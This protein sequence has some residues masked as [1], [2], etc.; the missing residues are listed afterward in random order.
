MLAL[1]ADLNCFYVSKFFSWQTFNSNVSIRIELI[2]A[3]SGHKYLINV[4]IRVEL[5]IAKSGRKNL[6][7]VSIQVELIT[8][9]HR[10]PHISRDQVQPINK[11]VFSNFELKSSVRIY[12]QWALTG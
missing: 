4:S 10:D 9:Y 8:A 1:F 3:M 2:I 12:K 11:Q 7:N 6:I 5:I